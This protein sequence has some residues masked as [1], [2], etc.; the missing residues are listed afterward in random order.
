VVRWNEVIENDRGIPSTIQGSKTAIECQ[1]ESFPMVVV[2]HHITNDMTLLQNNSAQLPPINFIVKNDKS[3]QEQIE[4]IP[5]VDEEELEISKE[6][7]DSNT[8]VQG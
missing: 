6:K 3:T 7:K 4:D 1:T 2:V 5:C 8:L